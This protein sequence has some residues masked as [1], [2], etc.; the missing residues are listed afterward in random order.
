MKHVRQNILD[1]LAHQ[2]PQSLDELARTIP[3]VSRGFLDAMIAAGDLTV[4]LGDADRRYY[5]LTPEKNLF[6]SL[7][8]C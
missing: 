4:D 6:K 5:W 1:A 2:Q 3:G 7:Q 8:T